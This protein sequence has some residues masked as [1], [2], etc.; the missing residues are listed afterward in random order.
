MRFYERPVVFFD[1]VFTLEQILRPLKGNFSSRLQ[2]SVTVSFSALTINILTYL[3]THSYRPRSI[4]VLCLQTSIHGYSY[5]TYF[6]ALY[7]YD[8]T[9]AVGVTAIRTVAYGP[10][11]RAVS[12]WWFVCLFVNKTTQCIR[13]FCWR[14][15]DTA[16]LDRVLFYLFIFRAVVKASVATGRR[17]RRRLVV[18]TLKPAQRDLL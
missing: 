12:H 14:R 7:S 8:C 13:R 3:H 16:R 4:F 18:W 10:Q 1:V 17:R 2:R 9:L 11:V 15:R 6:D 5:L